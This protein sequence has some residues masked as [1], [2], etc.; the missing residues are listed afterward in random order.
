MSS[1]KAVGGRLPHACPWR[2]SAVTPIV[3]FNLAIDRCR[4]YV[5]DHW[6]SGPRAIHAPLASYTGLNFMRGH[7]RCARFFLLCH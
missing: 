1:V 7:G 5:T 2:R 4:P 6:I 3:A